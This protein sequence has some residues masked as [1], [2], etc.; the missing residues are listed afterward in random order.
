LLPGRS[1]TIIIA[2]DLEF[3]DDFFLI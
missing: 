1:S 3:I 2:L